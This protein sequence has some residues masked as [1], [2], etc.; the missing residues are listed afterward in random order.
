MLIYIF[1]LHKKGLMASIQ[2]EHWMSSMQTV[3]F[4]S[5]EVLALLPLIEASVT[6]KC[7][8]EKLTD[9]IAWTAVACLAKAKLNRMHQAAA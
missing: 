8:E 4:N 5:D 7:S 9:E 1:P 2:L 3:S 6:Q